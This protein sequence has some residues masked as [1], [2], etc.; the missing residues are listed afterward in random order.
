MQ[1]VININEDGKT[2]TSSMPEADNMVS[3]DN[4]AGGFDGGGSPSIAEDVPVKVI[5][6]IPPQGSDAPLDGGSG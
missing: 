5:T 3:G 2:S 6:E 1:I 4:T